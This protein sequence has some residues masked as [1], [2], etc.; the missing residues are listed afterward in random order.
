MLFTLDITGA[1][2]GNRRQERA[3]RPI[4]ASPSRFSAK[5]AAH[6]PPPN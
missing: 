2:A 3:G 6:L 5:N 1:K 4:K